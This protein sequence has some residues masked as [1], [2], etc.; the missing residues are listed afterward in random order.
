[1]NTRQIGRQTELKAKKLLEEDGWLV[2]LVDMPQK[3]K[4]NQD[5]FGCWDILA[6]KKNIFKLVQIKTNQ[7][8]DLRECKNF[9]QEYFYNHPFVL[10]EV[11]MYDK[12]KKK[13]NMRT[14]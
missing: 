9:K 12:K 1:M 10:C 6:V 2:H 5:M 4:K 11:W 3:F 7:W 14:L 13:W 8:S